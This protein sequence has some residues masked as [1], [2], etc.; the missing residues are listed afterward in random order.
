MIDSDA[1]EQDQQTIAQKDELDK[2][3]A[4][5]TPL[6]GRAVDEMSVLQEEFKSDALFL[7]K[8]NHLTEKY[9]GIRRTRPDGNCFF[10]S[11]GFR[12]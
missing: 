9:A 11:V 2:E 1:F 5:T 4:A 12:C 3:I 10:R 7:G 8:V 6:V